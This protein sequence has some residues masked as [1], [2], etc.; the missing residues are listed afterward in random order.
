MEL[1][2]NMFEVLSLKWIV[3]YVD[4]LYDD[5]KVYGDPNK[6]LSPSDRYVVETETYKGQ[7]HKISWGDNPYVL[8]KPKGDEIDKIKAFATIKTTHDELMELRRVQGK[9]RTRGLSINELNAIE[10]KIKVLFEKYFGVTEEEG[11]KDVQVFDGVSEG[12][13]IPNFREE[14]EAFIKEAL[15]PFSGYF[16]GAK[17]LSD[18]DFETLK[19][20]T[21]Q[22]VFEDKGKPI[23]IGVKRKELSGLLIGKTYHNIYIHFDKKNKSK[24]I[25]FL[26]K[27][28]G[29]FSKQ[30]LKTIGGKFS[31]SPSGGYE[32]YVKNNIKY[33]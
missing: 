2:K 30:S 26:K 3:A 18:D 28:F 25:E 32:K 22:M 1:P 24:Y 16:K 9:F 19:E 8:Y 29:N 4:S 6:I 12:S 33:Y 20:A 7:V 17:I 27:T 13:L 10:E 11:E 5:Y 23:L 14:G 21:I 15:K 31:E